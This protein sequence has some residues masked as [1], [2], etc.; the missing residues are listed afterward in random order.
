MNL[1]ITRPRSR[2]ALSLALLAGAQFLVAVDF[3]IVI[4]ALPAIGQALGF[5]AQSLQW[6]VSAYTVVLGGFLMLG[7]RA[8]D[9]IGPRRMFLLGLVLFGGASLT[10]GFAAE[11]DV[12]VTA[13][14]VQGLGAALLTPATLALINTG[15]AE[16]PERTRA[17]SVWGAAGASGA[18]VGVLGGGMLT[19]YLGWEWVFFV[20]VPVALS[21]ALAAPHLLTADPPRESKHRRFDLPGALLATAGSTLVVLGL[22]TGPETGWNSISGAGAV[23]IGIVLLGGFLLVENNTRNPLMPLRLLRTRSLAVAMGLIF[24]FMG[25]VGTQYYLFTTYLQTVLG[26]SALQTGLAFLPL[27][28]LSIVASAKLGPILLNRWGS[29]VALC[30]GMLGVGTSMITLAMSMS[31]DG[32]YW[33]AFP[34]LI[35]WGLGAGVAFPAVFVTAGSGVSPGQQGVVSALVTTSQYIGLSVGLAAL[36]AVATAGLDAAPTDEVL[37]GGLRTAGLV[38]ALVTIAGAALVL[39]LKPSQS[40]SP[41]YRRPGQT[42][43]RARRSLHRT[44]R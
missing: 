28:M 13:R 19:H 23:A 24:I 16:G 3:D 41:S 7:G 22:I 44:C 43:D 2:P 4:V 26:Y 20:N 33:T 35:L 39:A 31:I 17:L 40:T 32:A 14:A 11:P 25:T 12:L 10:A 18:A 42:E 8:T 38:A 30:T 36:V 15:F 1:S 21:A 37:V 5:T 9:R 6:V 27:S 34:G 29:R